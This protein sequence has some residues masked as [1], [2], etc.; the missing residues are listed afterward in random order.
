[1]CGGGV[2]VWLGNWKRG[3]GEEV[4]VKAK[5]NDSHQMRKRESLSQLVMIAGGQNEGGAEKGGLGR[6]REI[7]G[8]R[9]RKEGEEGKRRGRRLIAG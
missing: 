9:K 1:M 2:L 6:G 7:G 5:H 8:K 3:G 4:N